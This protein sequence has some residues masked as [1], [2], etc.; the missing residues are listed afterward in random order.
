MLSLLSLV[1]LAASHAASMSDTYY[2]HNFGP[3]EKGKTHW[4]VKCKRDPFGPAYDCEIVAMID[5]MQV[6]SDQMD[7][8]IG[9]AED[10]PGHRW[11]FTWS[12]LVGVK[13]MLVRIDN[14]KPFDLKIIDQDFS[15][16][17]ELS[18][19]DQRRIVSEIQR[20]K[21]VFE[22]VFGK[23]TSEDKHFDLQYFRTAY[24]AFS[25]AC[26]IGQAKR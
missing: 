18:E 11:L 25:K 19:A 7:W 17:A 22:R 3:E 14:G 6:G 26:K 16:T 13:S 9:M 20:G 21:V 24:A 23:E 5:R 8:M 10:R 1:F 15:H 12:N 2:S 4:N